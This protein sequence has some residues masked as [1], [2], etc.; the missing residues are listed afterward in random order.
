MSNSTLSLVG[1][2]ALALIWV[3]MKIR[4]LLTK[5]APMGYENDAGFHFGDPPKEEWGAD[6]DFGLTAMNSAQGTSPRRPERLCQRNI[7]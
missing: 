5:S 4:R 6:Q 1:V 3:V 7:G 2:G